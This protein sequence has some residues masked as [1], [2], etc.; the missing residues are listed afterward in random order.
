[1]TGD[2]LEP[3]START[4]H[5]HPARRRELCI[6]LGTLASWRRGLVKKLVRDCES[7]TKILDLEPARLVSLIKG[8]DEE[9]RRVKP[10]SAVRR[11]AEG[12]AAKPRE[13]REAS[14]DERRFAAV[15][16][17]HPHACVASLPAAEGTAVVAWCDPLYPPALR[18]LNDPPLCLFVAADAPD[19]EIARR[20]QVLCGA[21]T[22]AVVGTR[23]PSPYGRDMAA[24]LGSDL[25]THGLL[26]VSGLALGVDA[27]AQA[28]AVRAARGVRRPA[29]VAVLGC[30][31][32]VV[33]PAENAR[34]FSAVAAEGL[35]VSEFAWGVPARSWR[36]PARNRVMAAVSRGVIV[37]EG[38]ARSG[39][40]I[41]ADFALDLGREVLAVPG[42]AGKR[43][44]QA[45]H[46]YLRHG[47]AICESAADAVRA[48]ASVRLPEAESLAGELEP[49]LVE[50]LLEAGSD[51]G[52]L[53]DV[54]RALERGVMRADQVAAACGLSVAE[55]GALLGELEVDGLV[56]VQPG[57]VFRLRRR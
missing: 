54:L 47:A 45:P 23:A 14:A 52:R 53:A 35:L 42:E 39:S 5:G 17:Q 18:Q 20:L 41:T 22:A 29:T 40:R 11:A 27:E 3:L 37:V 36:F 48:I 34:H 31:A 44:T 33:Y 15:L 21:H 12:G 24:L 25:T 8:Y 26:V 6:W 49:A 51:S 10:G 9:A 50:R 16:G 28:A 38:S 1:M 32:D 19:A 43:L 13:E 4:L 7:L 57:G 30:G 55:A 56:G 46:H 2:R